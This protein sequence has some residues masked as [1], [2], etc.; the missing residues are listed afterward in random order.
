[1]VARVVLA[2]CAVLVVAW[3][4]V[5][6]R[7]ERVGQDASGRVFTAQAPTESVVSDAL[8]GLADAELLNPDPKW[9]MQRAGLLLLRDRPAEA[10]RVAEDVVRRQPA[11]V[12]AWQILL[13]ATEGIDPRRAAEAWAAIKRLN[14]LATRTRAL[15]L[16]ARQVRS[17]AGRRPS[18]AA[19]A[20]Q[21][22]EPRSRR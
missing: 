12:E 13:Q 19:S 14:P 9:H 10:A 20:A 22:A 21:P 4:G 6:V 1:M 11:D 8:D 18:G 7:D 17:A 16:R 2:F 3:L 15:G 5:L